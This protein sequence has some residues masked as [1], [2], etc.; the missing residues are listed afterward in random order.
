MSRDSLL[1]TLIGLLVGFIA[2]FMLHESMA[3]RQPA[4]SFVGMAEQIGAGAAPQSPAPIVGGATGP[5][6]SMQQVQ[7]LRQYVEENPDDLEALKVLANLNLSIRNL[8]RASELF[9]RY[10]EQ[11]DDDLEVLQAYGNLSYDQQAWPKAAELYERYLEISP[12]NHGVQTDLGAVYR[13]LGR[14]EDALAQFESVL[15]DKPDHWEARF[16]EVLVKT[17]DLRDYEG[18]EVS[19][20]QLQTLRPGDPAVERL[21]TEL[22]RRRQGA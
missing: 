18:A 22:E 19:L 8:S 13:Y 9:E 11:K 5:Q 20:R 16:N 4:P 6:D 12:S 3:S 10:V 17:V 2:G 21:A 15:R 14:Y 1:Y 7:R